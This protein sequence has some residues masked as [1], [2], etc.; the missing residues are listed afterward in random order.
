MKD[1][2]LFLFPDFKKLFFARLISSIGDKFYTISL[3]WYILSE[4]SDNGKAHLGL[5]MAVNLLPVILFGPFIGTL[6]DRWNKKMCLMIADGSR[7]IL[8]GL[9]S[10]LILSG[11]LNLLWI[12]IITFLQALFVPLFDTA[13]QSSISL[14]TN[15][16]Y[17]S[18]AVSVN[19]SVTQVSAVLGGLLGSLMIHLVHIEGAFIFN[20]ISYLASL[21]F[22]SQI[23][24]NLNT[25]TIKSPFVKQ[26]K[27]GI[28]YISE[29]VSIKSLL[30]LFGISNLFIAPI[31]ILLP[32]LVKE[33]LEKGPNILAL[34]ETSLALG[35]LIISI[36]MSFKL[37]MKN[38][39][40][41]MFL[42]SLIL[43]MALLTIGSTSWLWLIMTVL[44]FIGIMLSY[45]NNTAFSLFH[46]KISDEMK[47]RFF[48]VLYTVVYAV[49]PLSYSLVG[50]A[51][52]KISTYSIFK[53]CG[54]AV[55]ILSFFF[56]LIPK[57]NQESSNK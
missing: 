22:V 33:E 50:F 25:T 21:F 31:L 56:L 27:E 2:V 7:F 6:T 39:Y 18:K 49:M 23:K 3:A 32:I 8:V 48:S 46:D 41:R 17:A 10:F 36:F 15:K 47:G 40:P 11:N 52:E 44:F 13:T 43:G 55:M 38:V 20:T 34:L 42:S 29:H 37:N 1:H 45:V 35:S 4:S 26:F 28:K 54:T 57:I 24:T 16:D 30:I 53:I 19:S 51:S 12:Y 5:L 14:L 9:L